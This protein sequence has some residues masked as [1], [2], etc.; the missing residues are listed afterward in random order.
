MKYI[1]YF[2]L[3]TFSLPVVSAPMLRD[4]TV[5]DTTTTG[6]TLKKSEAFLKQAVLMSGNKP[7]EA[8]E[9][10]R[11]AILT[12]EKKDDLREANI[13][14]S[15]GKLLFRLQKPEALVQLSKAEILFKNNSNLTGVSECISWQA[16]ILEKNGQFTEAR[17]KYNDLFNI[18]IQA[19]EPVLAG[20]TALKECDV[21]LKK[22]AY[23]EAFDYADR[24]K[25]A[26]DMVCRKDSLGAAY[27]KIALIK[28][29]MGKPKLAEYYIVYKALP[30]FSS[31]DDF[32]GRIR[33]FD[34]LARMYRDQKK[35][36]QAKWF[37][38]QSKTQSAAI[39]DTASTV[40]SLLN[41][42]VLKTLT[43]ELLLAHQDLMEAEVLS[44]K[45]NCPELTTAFRSRYRTLFKKLDTNIT[46]QESAAL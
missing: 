11:K 15:M 29:Q 16:R 13:R 4:T 9:N 38:L 7:S 27:L 14:L 10:Y 41:L 33:S 22:K 32:K 40:T 39:Q 18:Q 37:Y 25:N 46:A 5:A 8:V 31:A 44:K 21:F 23:K 28:K 6:D 12:A 20:N 45:G 43:G 35:Y 3:L 42:T 26:Y 19:G 24:A 36:S 1:L 17:K 30:Y 34:F 2:V